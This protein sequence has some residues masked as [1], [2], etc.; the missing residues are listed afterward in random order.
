MK[1]NFDKFGPLILNASF[2]LSTSQCHACFTSIV[3]AKNCLQCQLQAHIAL[4][5]MLNWT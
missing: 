2:Q 4:F 1:L 3:R 5:L